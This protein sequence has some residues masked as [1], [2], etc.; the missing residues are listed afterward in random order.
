M[1]SNDFYFALT[2]LGAFAVF[3]VALAINYVQYRRWLKQAPLG[4]DD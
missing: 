3:G 1:Q 4:T 2:T